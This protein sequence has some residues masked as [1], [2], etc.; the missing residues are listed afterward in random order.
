MNTKIKTAPKTKPVVADTIASAAG[1]LELDPGTIKLAKARGADGFRGH[2]I[3]VAKLSS[4]LAIHPEIITEAHA[5]LV[6][7]AGVSE[8]AKAKLQATVDLLHHR[9][10]REREEVVLKSAVVDEYARMVA[11]VQEEARILMDREI[12]AVFIARLKSKIKA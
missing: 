9:L 1:L 2:R 5:A 7:E 12:Y 8:L 6:K 4:W 10:Q 11:I 3:D